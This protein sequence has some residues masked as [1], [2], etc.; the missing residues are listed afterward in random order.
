MS[1]F[2]IRVLL[3]NASLQNYHALATK[4]AE[5]RVLDVIQADDGQLYKMPPAEYYYEGDINIMEVRDA[6]TAIASTVV[7]GY[8]VFVTEGGKR[9]WQ[10]LSVVHATV[11]LPVRRSA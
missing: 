2:T 3:Q 7:H 6:V 11:S 5:Y 8:Q 9:A 4:L 10:G 1:A